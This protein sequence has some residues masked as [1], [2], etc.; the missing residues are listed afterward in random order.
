MRLPNAERAVVDLEKLSGYCLNSDHPRGKHKARVFAA[1]LGLTTNDADMLRD[2]LLDAVQSADAEP[3]LLDRYGQQY[4][5]D[6]GM[7]TAVGQATVRSYWIVR[8]GEDFPRLA[9]CFLP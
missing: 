1:A 8:S 7:E 9:T 3:T 5:I 6:F 4:R 2:A